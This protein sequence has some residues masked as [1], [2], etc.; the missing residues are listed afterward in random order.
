MIIF[1]K[2]YRLLFKQKYSIV[3]KRVSDYYTLDRCYKDFTYNPNI[4]IT[5][6]SIGYAGKSDRIEDRFLVI[7]SY[8][9]WK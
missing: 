5:S 6:V 2:L 4:E 8:N 1:K 9:V 7:I 3:E